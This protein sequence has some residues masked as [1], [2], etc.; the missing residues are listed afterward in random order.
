M[1]K[2]DDKSQVEELKK[3]VET[4]Q[5]KIEELEKQASFNILDWEEFQEAKLSVDIKTLLRTVEKGSFTVVRDGF[6]KFAFAVY[7]EKDE[8]ICYIYWCDIPDRYTCRLLDM[9]V[10]FAFS[11]DKFIITDI[12]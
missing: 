2:K 8:C 6:G 10:H 5:K 11:K 12:N 1:K 7:N 9:K 3:Q 4:L